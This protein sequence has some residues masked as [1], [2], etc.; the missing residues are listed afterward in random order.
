MASGSIKVSVQG[1]KEIERAI[2]GFADPRNVLK[3]VKN[4]WRQ[5]SKT[6]VRN[7][8]RAGV[9]QS[10]RGK[11]KLA[12]SYSAGVAGTNLINLRMDVYSRLKM[13]MPH[14]F[15]P[16]YPITA[17]GGKNLAI[18][19]KFA[20]GMGLQSNVATYKKNKTLKSTSSRT[21]RLRPK[22]LNPKYTFLLE[23]G[24][25]KIIMMKVDDDTKSATRKLQKK[26][27]KKAGV[28]IKGQTAIPMFVLQKQVTLRR[29]TRVR[30]DFRRK[31]LGTIVDKTE[32]ELV[33]QF[34]RMAATTA[35]GVSRGIY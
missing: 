26:G 31:V 1:M 25:K 11:K 24:G 15:G 20:Q 9:R 13:S 2:S 17:K 5:E 29:R 3:V 23:K 34:N 32:R 16:L 27:F 7:T 28:S 33:R 10:F 4:T 35:I 21:T 14:E 30:F 19:T 22:H 18:P 8:I 6:T 12:S